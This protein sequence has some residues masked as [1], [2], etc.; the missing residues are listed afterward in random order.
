MQAPDMDDGLAAGSNLHLKSASRCKTHKK[1]SGYKKMMDDSD[2]ADA[3]TTSRSLRIP[4]HTVPSSSDLS[5]R[6]AP[7]RYYILALISIGIALVAFVFVGWTEADKR[8]AVLLAGPLPSPLPGLPP[9][10]PPIPP[11]IP[12]PST[13]LPPWPPPSPSP[14]LPPPPLLPPRQPPRPP[15]LPLPPS[16]PPAPAPPLASMEELHPLTAE[17]SSEFDAFVFPA[18]SCIDGNLR[19]IC[20]TAFEKGAWLSVE[21]PEEH[22]PIGRVVV[23]NRNDRWSYMAW[24]GEIEVWVGTYSGDT[25]SWR[26]V[27]CGAM[28]APAAVGPFTFLCPPEARADFLKFVT[29]KQ[30]GAKRPLTILELKVYV[31]GSPPPAPPAPPAL[32]LSPPPPP[33]PPPSPPSPP[34]PPAPL[35]PPPLPSSPSP[36][37]PGKPSPPPSLPTPLHVQ[38]QRAIDGNAH[39]PFSIPFAV[40]AHDGR[41][42]IAPEY[43]LADGG[44]RGAAGVWEEL[45]I[46]GANWAGFQAN[47]CVHELWNFPLQAYLDFLVRHG[48]NLVRLPLSAT[49]VTWPSPGYNTTWHCGEYNGW[50][51]LDVLDHVIS[52]LRDAGIFVMLDMHT[53]DHPEGN[54]GMWCWTGNSWCAHREESLVFSAWQVVARH[55]CGQPN[56]IMADVFNEP[57]MAD[58]KAWAGFVQRIGA[59]IHDFCPRW[60]IVAQGVG[61]PGWWWGE[62]LQYAATVPIRLG[63]PNKLVLSAHVYGHGNLPYLHDR[64]FP[65]NM[66]AIWDAHFGWVPSY[67]GAPLIIGEWGGNW[68]ATEWG[69]RSFPS[70]SAWQLKFRDYLKSKRL[71]SV[72]WTLN[73][74]SFKTGS[75]FRDPHSSEKVAMLSQ[76]PSTRIVDLQERWPLPPAPPTPPPPP[77]SPPPP[78]PPPPPTPPPR[79]PPPPP[80]SPPPSPQTPPTPPP[81]SAPPPNL[82][83]LYEQMVRG[84][85]APLGAALAALCG[86]LVFTTSARISNRCRKASAPAAAVRA[87]TASRPKRIASAAIEMR[88][89]RQP[90]DSAGVESSVAEALESDEDDTDE[91]YSDGVNGMAGGRKGGTPTRVAAKPPRETSRPGSDSFLP[92]DGT[93][94]ADAA[95]TQSMAAPKPPPDG[96]LL[97]L[98]PDNAL[99]PAQPVHGLLSLCTA[100]EGTA[101]QPCASAS[102]DATDLVRRL[103][104]D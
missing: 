100:C 66:P 13:P 2:M 104:L 55:Y 26:A 96:R 79:A 80:R 75:L 7:V 91:T 59:H 54:N 45:R 62:N 20:A 57:W 85:L 32:P 71:S 31:A 51:S 35:A 69:Y 1:V 19:S 64:S 63:M 6:Y 29:L 40:S 3:T 4:E 8:I 22:S 103:D 9:N 101:G 50:R 72:Y 61:G 17:L 84:R 83:P 89:A 37:P 88:K 11:P 90:D 15:S 16:S 73:D 102:N 82:P 5:Q 77:P 52:R 21:M 10:A 30:R 93:A 98:R 99:P 56:V 92:A 68:E 46:R 38:W 41:I 76:L 58:W 24:L 43:R 53:L 87:G 65:A 14:S 49:I 95:A 12:L 74:N 42:W 86:L 70:T 48:I 97:L 36:F 44:G 28:R 33:S 23:I 60:L 18:S 81:P 34:A 78:A 39:V 27:P 47:G 67:T 25:T 94:P